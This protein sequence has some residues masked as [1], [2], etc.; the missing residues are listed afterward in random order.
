MELNK[1]KKHIII[2]KLRWWIGGLL[3]V[4]TVINY[5]DRQTLSF[6]AP[7]LKKEFSWSNSDF[8]LVIIAFRFAAHDISS[9]GTVREGKGGR[10]ARFVRPE[11]AGRF[12][13]AACSRGHGPGTC[14]R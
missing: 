7:Y 2:P 5:I 13:G 11:V 3:F 4:S 12:S 6:L 14:G 9:S 10:D 1:T 8:A